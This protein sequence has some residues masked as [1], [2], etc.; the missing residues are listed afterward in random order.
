MK[1]STG[2]PLRALGIGEIYDRAI[3]I[4]VRNAPIF[5]LIVLTLL[6]PY[7][8]AQYF[9]L[10]D[11]S[12]A[13]TQAIQQIQH[14][15]AHPAAA[16]PFALFTTPHLEFFALVVV[17]SALFSPFVNNAIAV[18]VANVYVGKPPNFAGGFARVFRRWAPLLGTTLLGFVLFIVTYLA[19]V[20]SLTLLAVVGTLL[21]RS[22]LLIAVLVFILAA[23]GFLALI[24]FFILLFVAYAFALYS[25]TLEDLGGMQAIRLG[26]A[27]VFGRREIG[28][29]LLLSLSYIAL[30]IG[31]LA[32]SALL[33]ALALAILKSYAAQLAISVILNSTLTAFITIVL[34]VYYYDVRTRREGLD[35]EADLQRLTG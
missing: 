3:T 8:I 13:F 35:L 5:T 15:T 19:G 18:G 4:Y 14:P 25:V 24:L 20:V 23:I 22:A 6:V 32:A 17:L 12:A 7:A 28:K 30:E 27:R 26:V 10:P 33:G 29:A 11:Q 21:V 2:F 1:D 34:S 31:V 16:D 9:T